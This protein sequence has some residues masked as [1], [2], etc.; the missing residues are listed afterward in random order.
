MVQKQFNQQFPFYEIWYGKIN[1]SPKSAL[2]FRY[3]LLNGEKKESAL[4]AIFFTKNHIVAQKEIYSLESLVFKDSSIFLPNGTLSSS[5]VQGNLP[6]IQWDMT[7]TSNHGSNDLMPKFIQTFHISKSFTTTPMVD[8]RFHGLLTVDGK[9]IEIQNGYGMMGHVWGKRYAQE[10]VWAHSN[11]FDESGILFEGLSARLSI[12]GIQ[13]SPLTSLYVRA[14]E[15]DY[16]FNRLRDLLF[17]QSLYKEGYWNFEAHSKSTSVIGKCRALP[18]DIATITYTDT[19]NS[20]LYC[21]NSKLASMVLTL[22]DHDRKTEDTW[23]SYETTAF[24]WVTRTPPST[25]PLL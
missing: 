5:K 25:P 8:G 22:I 2:W 13:T 1:F 17:S 12:C 21:H 4:W 16:H 6:K 7:Y 11:Q 14:N 24:E 9:R 10:W 3:T 18:K 19:N 15:H 23:T 20:S